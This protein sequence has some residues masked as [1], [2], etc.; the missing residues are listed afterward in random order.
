M[1]HTW[2]LGVCMNKSSFSYWRTTLTRCTYWQALA[3]IQLFTHAHGC[4]PIQKF[5]VIA[6]LAFILAMH[7]CMLHLQCMHHGQRIFLGFEHKVEIAFISPATHQPRAYIVTAIDDGIHESND[8]G[9][10]SWT[11]PLWK[12]NS[13]QVHH[14]MKCVWLQIWHQGHS[15]HTQSKS[16][17]STKLI[18]TLLGRRGPFY[19]K[20]VETSA[21]CAPKMQT[22]HC[23]TAAHRMVMQHQGSNLS[24]SDNSVLAKS[25]KA[26]DLIP[27]FTCAS[28]Q[29]RV[30]HRTHFSLSFH[31][32]R[33]HGMRMC[34][35]SITK[36]CN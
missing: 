6:A 23:S 4:T 26:G 27:Y 14:D 2:S 29:R 24:C 28:G 3:H 22:T 32:W 9:G 35:D 5:I 8:V 34:C 10:A 16:I 19:I 20:L 1:W 21:K 7:S 36:S 31:C 17:L 18:A 13:E 30:G 15:H 33:N 11:H 12:Y 25:A